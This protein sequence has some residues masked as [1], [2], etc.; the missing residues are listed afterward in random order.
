[1][2]IKTKSWRDMIEVHPAANLFPMMSDEELKALGEDI[3]QHG[4]NEPIAITY[5]KP[6]GG[7]YQYS[8]IDGRNRLDAMEMAGLAP[9]LLRARDRWKL[10][11]AGSNQN[12]VPQP[13]FATGNP[14]DYVLSRNI[15]RR[16]LTPE[17][18][19][20]LIANV[21]KA[22]PEKSNRQIAEQTK[23]DHKTVASVR[24]E[25]QATGEIPQLAKTV[26]KDGKA[27]SPTAQIARKHPEPM[28]HDTETAVPTP[29]EA[30]RKL[31]DQIDAAVALAVS[32]SPMQ[33]IIDTL[34]DRTAALAERSGNVELFA[35]RVR[36]RID[37]MERQIGQAQGE[38]S[39]PRPTDSAAEGIPEFLKRQ[40]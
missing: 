11:L 17:Q 37:D 3:K 27:R 6:G 23:A 24:A 30:I 18:K 34:F 40:A 12:E 31:D 33:P 5:Q 22:Q 21:L 8:L 25:K 20:D 14:F 39:K 13:V 35:K 1:M 4:L 2:T 16:H 28:S 32:V 29:Q 15:H 10:E 9:N 19:R 7:P 36:Q 26:G 38:R